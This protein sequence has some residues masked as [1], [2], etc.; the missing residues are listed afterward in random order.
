MTSY[1][2]ELQMTLMEN[3]K[4]IEALETISKE[5]DVPVEEIIGLLT[6]FCWDEEEG[7]ELEDWAA[8]RV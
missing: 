4:L 8:R 3:T 2:K 5:T 1:T 7:G 6:G